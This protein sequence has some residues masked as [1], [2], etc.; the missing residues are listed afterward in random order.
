MKSKEIFFYFPVFLGGGASFVSK[1]I[2]VL[3]SHSADQK[4]DSSE[5]KV[6]QDRVHC[7]ILRFHASPPS[8]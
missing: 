6:L 3:E 2:S 8:N 5:A 1:R 4:E 7:N